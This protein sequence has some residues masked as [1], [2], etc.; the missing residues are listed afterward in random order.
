MIAHLISAL[1]LLI[2]H[3][4]E[5]TVKSTT[6]P[7][8]KV[9]LAS[10]VEGVK[11]QAAPNGR[12]RLASMVDQCDF[13]GI[14]ACYAHCDSELS[15]EL[16]TCQQQCNSSSNYYDCMGTCEAAAISNDDTCRSNCN[17]KCSS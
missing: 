6:V 14:N 10:V 7:S 11:L 13:S 2:S 5:A 17:M 16:W 1:L 4:P 12:V 15:Q 9:I 8:D 3:Q